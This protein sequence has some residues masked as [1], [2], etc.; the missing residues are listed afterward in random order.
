MS[1]TETPPPPDTPVAGPLERRCPRCGSALAADQEWCLNCGAAAGTE[2]VEPRGWRVPLYL[3]GGLLAL[4]IIGVILAIVAL[5]DRNDVVAGNPT[6][7][8][9]PAASVPP[10]ATPTPSPPL[11]TETPLPSVTADPNA[12]PTV[13]PDPNATVSPTATATA[14]ESSTPEPTP[15]EDPGTTDSGTGS[16]FPGWTGADGDYTIIIE[17]SKTQS[18]AEKVAQKAQDGGL[19]DVGVLKSDDYSSL[20]GGYYV[21]FTGTYSSK[22]DAEDALDGVQAN[23]HDA[24]VRQIK[25]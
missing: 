3:G 1:T 15:T 22:S 17:S 25:S 16:T 12:T 6:P 19:P 4:A 11:A 5:T 21:V 23:F 8:P 9:S 20:N 13:S 14:T 10:G 2:V 18:G 24:Y 7:T